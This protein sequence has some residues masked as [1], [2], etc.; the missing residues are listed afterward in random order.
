MDAGTPQTRDT[1]VRGSEELIRRLLDVARARTGMDTAWVSRFGD[2]HQELAV[3]S[4]SL[5]GSVADGTVLALDGSYCHWVLDGRLSNI[6]RDTRAHPATRELEATASLG[7]GSYIG[8]P[9]RGAN[10]VVTGM[11]CAT[12]RKPNAELDEDQVRFLELLADA[13]ADLLTEVPVSGDR[14]R[15]LRDRVGSVIRNERLTCVFQPIVDLEAGQI[16]GYEALSRFPT[17]PARPDQW[18]ADAESVGLG[19]ALEMCAVRIAL[20]ALPSLP[21]DT[22]LSVNLSP[23]TLMSIDTAELLEREPHRLVIELTEHR[24]V[25]DYRRLR[26]TVDSLRAVG[27]RFAVDDAGAGFSSFKHILELAPDIVKIDLSICQGV[28]HDPVRGAVVRGMVELARQVPA[29]LVAEG[30]E[31]PADVDRLSVLGV[32][33]YQ[34][35]LFGRP[36]P[37]P[38]RQIAEMPD[39]RR[40]AETLATE[41]PPLLESRF[42]AALMHTAVPSAIVE[43]DGT[44]RA[45]NDRFAKLLRRDL[46]DLVGS[47]FQELTHPDDLDIDLERLHSC[48]AGER[49]SYRI[50]KRYLDP[51]GRSI[52][53]DLIVTLVRDRGGEPLY[54]ISHIIPV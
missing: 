10:G 50:A 1:R 7:L 11:F 43:L 53:T 12:S 28:H 24:R 26:E 21:A 39:A 40:T 16:I 17:E 49:D 29:A 3:V 45:L 30:V 8:V 27:V 5:P 32:D 23:S 46:D 47:T 20:S 42:E 41:A 34:G 25:A 4:S 2:D 44:L 31:D 19:V 54:F 33:L 36:A 22:Y 9:M 51:E 52:P 38:V 35:Y 37:V 13:A 15:R 6:V 48:L 18:F 14:R